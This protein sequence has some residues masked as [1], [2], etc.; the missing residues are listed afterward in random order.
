MGVYLDKRKTSD[1]M[2]RDPIFNCGGFLQTG[3][4]YP[5]PAPEEEWSHPGL[6]G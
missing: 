6:G 2:E 1:W 5:V 4:G 3:A